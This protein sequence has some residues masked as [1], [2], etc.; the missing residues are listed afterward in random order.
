MTK[1]KRISNLLDEQLKDYE[2][3]VITS[4]PSKVYGFKNIVDALGF[5]GDCA[6]EYPHVCYKVFKR[7][8]KNE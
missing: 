1:E 4:N 3:I 8:D 2:W 7:F 5:I 6:E